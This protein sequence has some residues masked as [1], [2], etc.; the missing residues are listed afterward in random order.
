MNVPGNSP[1]HLCETKMIHAMC[2][3]IHLPHCTGVTE[4]LG[5]GVGFSWALDY[6]GPCIA[7]PSVSNSRMCC[8]R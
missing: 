3:A 2:T 5:S 6:P 1:Q 4:A 7:R 8:I